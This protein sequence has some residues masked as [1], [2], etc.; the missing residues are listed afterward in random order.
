MDKNIEYD[1]EC[2]NTSWIAADCSKRLD[3]SQCGIRITTQGRG[4]G[5]R[6]RRK[7]TSLK[8]FRRIH[9]KK[10]LSSKV[11]L[12]NRLLESK[13]TSKLSSNPIF[14]AGD[15]VSS[16]HDICKCRRSALPLA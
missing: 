13:Y 3:Q 7:S 12:S 14:C 1:R 5:D 2:L 16:Y 9:E 11:I 15:W 4:A 10:Y 8:N 6:R